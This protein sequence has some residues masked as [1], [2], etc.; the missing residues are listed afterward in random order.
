MHDTEKKAAEITRGHSGDAGSA[1]GHAACRLGRE[2]HRDPARPKRAASPDRIIAGHG[3]VLAA[4]KLGLAEV[5]VMIAR[6]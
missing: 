5:P 2:A 6:G 3:R 4:Q 1:G